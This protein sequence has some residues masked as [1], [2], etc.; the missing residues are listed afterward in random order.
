MEVHKHSHHETHKKKW[1]A[2]LLEFFMLFLA[3]FLGFVAENIREERVEHKRAHEFAD[4]LLADLTNDTSWFNK[5]IN[6]IE[7]Q[8]PHMDEAIQL[9]IQPVPAT[10]ADVLRRSFSNNINYV[11]DAKL[12]TA[13]YNQMRSSGSLRYIHNSELTVALQDYY[14]VRIP[15]TT[16]A[17]QSTKKFF[18][19]Y[20]KSFFIEQL[21]NQ[22]MNTMQDTSKNWKPLIYG[23]N[24]HADQ[25]LSNIVSMDQTQLGIAAMFYKSALQKATELIQIINN[26]YNK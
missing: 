6:R 9:L 25:R 8:R 1:T 10:D 22:D 14:E 13:T 19:E 16:E 4:R 2:Y 11:S 17:S 15:R 5:E 24:S 20:I 21:R 26:E 23:R 18:D 3:V 7:R 12:N